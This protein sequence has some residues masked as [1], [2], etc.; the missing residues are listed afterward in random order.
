MTTPALLVLERPLL[1]PAF[2]MAFRAE[3]T[4]RRVPEGLRVRVAAVAG[5]RQGPAVGADAGPGGIHALHRLPHAAGGTAVV[6]VEDLQG[7]YLPTRLVTTLPLPPAPAFNGTPCVA[8]E[9][10][11]FLRPEQPA[12]AGM[13]AVRASVWNATAGAPAAFAMVLLR[14]PA[15]GRLLGRGLADERGQVLVPVAPGEPVDADGG[16]SPPLPRPA[17]QRR[18]DLLVELHFD[19]ALVLRTDPGFGP[20]AAAWPDLCD[21]L[22]QPLCPAFAGPGSPPQALTLATLR[23]GEPLVLAA[24]AGGLVVVH[25]A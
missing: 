1:R 15:K 20:R 13:A 5:G 23:Q 6:R 11:L 21:L 24:D 12:P 10:P 22:A 18:W 3:A 14:D 9:V 19:P 25:P 8:G 17:A 7:R 16:A 2:G 4:G